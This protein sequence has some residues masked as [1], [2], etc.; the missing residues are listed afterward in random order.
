MPASNLIHIGFED[1]LFFFSH[2]VKYLSCNFFQMKY[3][4]ANLARKHP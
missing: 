3:M 4:E 2:I 1:F